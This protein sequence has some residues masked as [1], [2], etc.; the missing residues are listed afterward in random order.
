MMIDEWRIN[1]IPHF[2]LS[3]Y[4]ERDEEEEEEGDDFSHGTIS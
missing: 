4:E 1:F 3:I 2:F